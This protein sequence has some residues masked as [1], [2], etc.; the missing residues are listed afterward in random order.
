MRHRKMLV[1]AVLAALV[2]PVTPAAADRS[3]EFRVLPYLQSPS[4]TGIRVTWFT[5]DGAPGRLTVHGGRTYDVPGQ[6]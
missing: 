2:L 1:V 5:E 6:A 4:A 3:D